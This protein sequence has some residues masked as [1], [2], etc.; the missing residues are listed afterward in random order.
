VRAFGQYWVWGGMLL[1]VTVGLI[2]IEIQS[3]DFLKNPLAVDRLGLQ[4]AL[5][6]IMLLYFGIGF[7]LLSQAK[8]ME[9]NARWL[10][11]NITK[12]EQMERSWQRSSLLILLLVGLIAA[13]LPIGPTLAIGRILNAL[14]FALLF[15]INLLVFLISLP[16]ALLFA[17][18][19]NRSIAEGA[20]IPPLAPQALADNVPPGLSSLGETVAMV[21][22]SAFWSIFAVVVV[23]ALLFFLRE[24][25]NLS[26][27]KSVVALW[28][29]FIAWLE[30]FWWR[31]RMRVNAV[32][33]Q[34]PVHL[35]KEKGREKGGE[36]GK[37]HWRFIRLSGLSPREQIR[38]FYLSTVRRAGERGIKRETAETPLE[39]AEDLKDNWPE[40]EEEVEALTDAFLKAR[41]SDKPITSDDVPDV[42]ETWKDVRR[43]LKKRS[44][45][46]EDE[47]QQ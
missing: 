33:L 31:F 46:D 11:N 15:I 20:P 19:A 38:Y 40:V 34:F 29:R 28:Q 42:K 35:A 24:R 16:I 26:Q 36:S 2:S 43:Q 1:A 14:I 37:G 27:E 10:V 41:Y 21:L 30:E 44:S 23:L 47:P 8:L 7:W 25:K 45:P 39:Y 9:M 4:P 5:L 12:D 6:I 32:R 17:L 13:F 22:S 18:L 3:Y